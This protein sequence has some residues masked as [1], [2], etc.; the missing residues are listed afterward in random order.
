MSVPA[1]AAALN[2]LSI[3]SAEPSRFSC[4]GIIFGGVRHTSSPV[5]GT[6]G[7]TLGSHVFSY[8]S[9]PFHLTRYS[10]SPC[11][12]QRRGRR[13]G[14]LGYD[15]RS[16][17]PRPPQVQTGRLAPSHSD[18]LRGPRPDTHRASRHRA[19][20]ASSFVVYTHPRP[21]PLSHRCR[22]SCASAY[23]SPQA[24]LSDSMRMSR[25]SL[26]KGASGESS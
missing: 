7:G 20:L 3:S 19:S 22:P 17:A 4:P 26:A 11:G 2:S 15:E 13:Q 6:R 14:R 23:V 16:V 21:R 5:P 25:L 1:S 24:S 9:K 8:G 10:G 12:G 18:A